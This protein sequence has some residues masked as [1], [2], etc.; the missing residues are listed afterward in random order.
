MK[1]DEAAQ[2]LQG[3][4]SRLIGGSGLIANATGSQEA[5]QRIAAVLGA[6]Y[7]GFG[8]PRPR[9][10]A[11]ADCRNLLKL[12]VEAQAKEVH[13]SASLQVGF[14]ALAI[15][16]A[17]FASREQAAELVLA[18][19]LSTGA[20]WED[21]RMKGGAYGAFAHPDGLEPLFTLAT[22]RDPNPA[23]SLAAF[24]RIL[25]EAAERPIDGESLE[26]AIIGSYS[27][28][29][30]PRTGAEKGMAD[31]MRFLTGIDDGLRRRRLSSLI[32][33]EEADVRGAAGRLEQGLMH[34]HSAVV[35]GNGPAAQAA[36]A[37]GVPVRALP[38]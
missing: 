22:Y 11:L 31:F 4:R 37:L 33:L 25:R 12:G 6:R 35:A 14:A 20:L 2:E 21:I 26:K 19:R 8:S 38:V 16:S 32:D 23:R 10:E 3:L 15:P 13:G 18:H 30:R 7:A 34:A 1:A 29:T 28:E 36:E 5:L 17:P 9:S 27:K 24:P